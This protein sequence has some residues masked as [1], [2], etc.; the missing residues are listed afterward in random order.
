MNRPRLENWETG[1]RRLAVSLLVVSV[2]YFLAGKAGLLLAI[3]NA[4]VSVVWPATGI[5]IGALLLGG[6]ELWPAVFV[7]AFCVNL[8]TT[9]DPASSLGIAGG[10]TLE[11]V[12]G[13]YLANRFASGKNF[14]D[15]P[16]TLLTFA[17]LSGVLASS[18]AASVGTASLLLTHNASPGGITSVWGTWW[19]GDAIGAIEVTP[20]VLVLSQ[21]IST[22]H[23]VSELP[24]RTEGAI[25]AGLTVFLA[26]I[27]FARAPTSFLGGYPLIFL[28]LLPIIWAASRFGSFG[29]IAT[30]ATVSVIAIVA[31]VSHAGPFATLPPSSALLALRIFMGSL[32]LTALLVAADVSRHRALEGELYHTR[33]ELQ[34][35]LVERTAQLDA[36]RSLAHVGTWT[37]DA[38][39]KKVVWSEEMYP[40]LGYGEERFP[41]VLENAFQHVW[42]EDREALRQELRG[43]LHSTD[44]LHHESRELKLQLEL[45]EGE[46]RTILCKL[47]IATVENGRTA[48]VEGTVQDVTERERIGVELERLQRQLEPSPGTGQG[49]PIWMIPWSRMAGTDERRN[50]R[51]QA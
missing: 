10:N 34:R 16:N 45:P 9:W 27:V 21:R 47:R 25:V 42:R 37:Y 4:S 5:A 29:A 33:K 50:S 24:T 2:G 31:T 6:L 48:K 1:R 40:I 15:R 39:S 19:L 46:R 44:P 8:T 35:M 26:L 28:V 14:L 7:G 13:A 41:V 18:L 22:P 20:F 17:L 11:A 32:A 12:A 3:G 51:R 23:P 38:T 43:A 30:T 49:L 36:A